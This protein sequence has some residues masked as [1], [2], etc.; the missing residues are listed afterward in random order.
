M[1]TTD[2]PLKPS[3]TAYKFFEQW[4]RTKVFVSDIWVAMIMVVSFLFDKICLIRENY[5]NLKIVTINYNN[6]VSYM[7]IL[8]NHLLELLELTARSMCY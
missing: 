1:R 4:L 3:G 2:T 8:E 5:N 7:K 6:K